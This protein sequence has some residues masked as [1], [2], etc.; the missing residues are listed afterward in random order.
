M[1]RPV[2]A[3]SMSI[4]EV[5]RNL[6]AKVTGGLHSHLKKRIIYFGLD[7]SHFLGGAHLRGKSSSNKK[8]WSQV[9][10]LRS[11]GARTSILQLKRALLESGAEYKCEECNLS[12][13]RGESISLQIDHRDRNWRNDQKEN[14]RFL[15]PN[16][17][18]QT[19]GWCGRKT[20]NII[21]S[22]CRGPKKKNRKSSTC[23]SCA[24][25][26][27][28][29]GRPRKSDRPALSV[30]W[31]EIKAMGYSAV[32]RKYGVTDNAIRKW[33]NGLVVKQQTRRS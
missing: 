11:S 29:A 2:V 9:L 7:T 4:N 1:L 8:P 28:T 20:A 22:I 27:R 13:W 3:R 25:K 23:R 30:L 12:K 6:G 26:G 31:S 33:L 10:V 18:S 21:C 5:I 16:C 17:H 24:Q 15:C 32:G 19:E 14:L